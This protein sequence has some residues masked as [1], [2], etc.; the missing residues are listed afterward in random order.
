[1]N[2]IVNS[3]AEQSWLQRAADPGDK[4]RNVITITSAGRRQLR[5]LDQILAELDDEVFAPLSATEKQQLID[6]L[7]RVL[8]HIT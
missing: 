4:R 3:L 6:M 8:A 1:M 5:R 2:A 7:G